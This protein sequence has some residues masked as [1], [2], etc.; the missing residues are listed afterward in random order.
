MQCP[1]ERAMHVLQ[2]DQGC[3]FDVLVRPGKTAEPD[4]Y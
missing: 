2:A 1:G 4:I 3:D